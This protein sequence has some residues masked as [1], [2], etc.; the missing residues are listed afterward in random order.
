MKDYATYPKPVPGGDVMKGQQAQFAAA[1]SAFA[2][3][4]ELGPLN[5]KLDEEFMEVAESQSRDSDSDGE[6]SSSEFS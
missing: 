4:A 1:K 3:A 5:V 6:E 2:R